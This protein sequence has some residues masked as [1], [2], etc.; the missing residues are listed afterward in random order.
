MSVRLLGPGREFTIVTIYRAC[1]RGLCPAEQIGSSR[2]TPIAWYPMIQRST[3]RVS[4][5]S[6]AF[7]GI[8]FAFAV[9]G[10]GGSDSG[11][12]EVTAVIDSVPD[13]RSTGQRPAF[14]D[15]VVAAIDAVEAELGAG[16]QFFEVTA[17]A[18]FTNVF[19]AVDDATAAVA[20][21][22]VD[23]ALESPAPK[24]S[25][26]AGSTFSRDDVDFDPNLI[27]TEV[28][29]DLPMSSVDAMSVY[30]NGVGVTYVLAVTSGA[31]GFLDIVVG[32]QGQVFSVDPV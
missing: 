16:Q 2:S 4:T 12:D 24:Q 22:Y 9:G 14:V 8:V 15:D 29:A 26:A 11:G 1:R 21:A 5:A 28:S 32:P 7:V 6:V 27:A 20:Y 30:G 13:S 18:R 25:G 23:G 19:V 17:N 10:C 3:V 31:G